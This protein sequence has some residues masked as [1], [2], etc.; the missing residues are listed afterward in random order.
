LGHS[1]SQNSFNDSLINNSKNF[2]QSGEIYFILFKIKKVVSINDK[3]KNV[4]VEFTNNQI[5]LDM[6][7]W[8]KNEEYISYK[9]PKY[10]PIMDVNDY[11]YIISQNPIAFVKTIPILFQK[12]CIVFFLKK[13]IISDIVIGRFLEIKK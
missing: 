1:H 2:S 5:C 12:T 9:V 8:T 3:I 6:D 10:A 7:K 13:T 4:F 11:K